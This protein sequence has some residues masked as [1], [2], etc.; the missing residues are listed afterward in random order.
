MSQTKFLILFTSVSVIVFLLDF[1][2]IYNWRKF[3]KRNNFH[4]AAV[5]TPII[6]SILMSI[7]FAYLNFSKFFHASEDYA[8]NFYVITTIWF[9]PKFLIVPV[10]LIKDLS[11]LF[12]YI[13]V[14]IKQLYA[15][16]KSEE[17]KSEI[18]KNNLIEE[19]K[20]DKNRRKIIENVAWTATALPFIIVADGTLN[21]VYDFKIHRL[22]LPLANLPQNLD[23]LKIV[24][25]SDM[26]FGSFTSN[27][28]FQEVR[29]MVNNL[30]PE[31]LLLTGDF[32]NYNPDEMKK[33]NSELLKLKADIGIYGCLGNHDHYMS[34]ERHDLLQKAIRQSGVNLLVNDN[35]ILNVHGSKINLASVD[36]SGMN[37]NFAK[38][39]Q[40]ES[41]IHKENPT[42]LM[43]HDPT[44][45]DKKILNKFPADLTL[46]GHTHGGQVGIE[47]DGFELMPVKM[48][49][50]RYAGHYQVKDQHLYVNR[51]LGTTGP[52]I[53]IGINP[54]ITLITLRAISNRV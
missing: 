33:F 11:R 17:V 25:I 42:I 37:Q 29:R 28:P 19:E 2:V 34:D 45:W 50:K 16:T 5:I 53:R 38:F 32:V 23:G 51:G 18:E 22:E 9:L 44:N 39:N 26:H 49:Y 40:V 6:I 10:L 24:Q 8:S 54:E 3:A 7:T 15:S 21:T 20:V 12:K 4:K 14:K 35:K 43:C 27:K 46:S 47:L 31:L 36:N 41:L 48:V 52:P 1:Y 13:F 30:K